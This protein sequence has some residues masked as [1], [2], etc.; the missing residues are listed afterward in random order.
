MTEQT[1]ITEVPKKQLTIREHLSGEAFRNTIASILPKH[2]TPERMARVA[3]T[4]LTRT[5]NLNRCTQQSFFDCM[6]LLSQW[7]LEPDG[8]HAHLIP[9]GDKCTVIIDYKGLVQLAMRSGTVR[10]IHADTVCENDVFEVDRGLIV[11]HAIDYRK[12]RGEVYA[13]YCIIETVNGG[14]KCEVMTIDEVNAIRDRSQA[15][16]TFLS[17]GRECPWNTDP[18]EMGKK[19]V[20]KRATKWTELSAEIRDAIATDDEIDATVIHRGATTTTADEIAGLLDG[21]AE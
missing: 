6:M 8:R 20:F 18:H 7:G 3:I 14:T 2:C 15:W 11:K 5:P 19:S 21:V 13:Y 12:P 17:K 16:K 10:R 4:A 1:T 9:F